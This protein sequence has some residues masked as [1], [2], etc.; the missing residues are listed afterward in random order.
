MRSKGRGIV[1]GNSKS[2][3]PMCESDADAGSEGDD[4]EAALVVI[5]VGPS[6][7]LDEGRGVAEEGIGT[8]PC[9]RKGGIVGEI[10]APDT[11]CSRTVERFRL[12]VPV[13]LGEFLCGRLKGFAVG[14]SY[15]RSEDL[16]RSADT[17]TD[18][19]E[20]ENGV[21]LHRCLGSAPLWMVGAARAS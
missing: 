17:A 5:K 21:A 7:R 11:W 1:S 2:A 15:R 19:L 14:P 4:H 16:S 6:I 13:E 9:F 10:V 20:A 18:S 8:N 12:H 3:M